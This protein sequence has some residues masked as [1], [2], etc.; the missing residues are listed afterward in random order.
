MTDTVATI[1]GVRAL[2]CDAGGG[3]LENNQDAVDLIAST[4]GLDVDLIVVPTQRLSGR[5]FDLSTGVAGDVI[6][7]FAMY[8]NKLVIVGDIDE[9][10]G[11]S[12][13]FAAWVREENR[14]RNVWFVRDLDELTARL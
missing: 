6:P 12:E 10:V 4:Y 1:G 5:F 7:K 14:G 13:S 9:Y 3:K 11:R 2:L 8:A